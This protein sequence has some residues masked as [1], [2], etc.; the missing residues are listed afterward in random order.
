MSRLNGRRGLLPDGIMARTMGEHEAS[1]PEQESGQPPLSPR[2]QG[3]ARAW[4]EW[5]GSRH[6]AEADEYAREVIRAAFAAGFE[7]GWRQ[8]GRLE[9]PPEQGR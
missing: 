3:E 4:V 7:A 8:R 6:Y 5:H 2:P 1:G 9:P